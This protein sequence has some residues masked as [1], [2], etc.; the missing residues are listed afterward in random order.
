MKKIN[1]L[2]KQITLT[3]KR[4]AA[5]CFVALVICGVVGTNL[6]AQTLK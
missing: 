2:T 5:L 6:A 1:V 3:P 4:V